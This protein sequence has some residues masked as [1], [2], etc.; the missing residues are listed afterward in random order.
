MEKVH[1]LFFNAN[2]K[3]KYQEKANVSTARYNKI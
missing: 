1:V 2:F 3:K